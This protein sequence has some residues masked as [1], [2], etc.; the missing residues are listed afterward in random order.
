MSAPQ[1]AADLPAPGQAQAARRKPWADEDGKEGKTFV[2]TLFT[3]VGF[4]NGRRRSGAGLGRG[5]RGR[6]PNSEREEGHGLQKASQRRGDQLYLQ[7]QRVPTLHTE[8]M[9]GFPGVQW[10]S[11]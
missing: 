9:R 5:R 11:P 8:R 6:N 1:S 7:Q 4:R 10:P 3:S 2:L